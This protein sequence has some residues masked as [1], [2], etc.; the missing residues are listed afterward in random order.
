MYLRVDASVK[1]F[2]KKKAKEMD[3]NVN[4]Y[5]TSLINE[6]IASEPVIVPAKKKVIRRKNE[7]SN[8]T[9]PA[10]R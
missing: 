3:R 9:E 2:L 8:H 7:V 10:R 6:K 1:D 4:Y 5:L